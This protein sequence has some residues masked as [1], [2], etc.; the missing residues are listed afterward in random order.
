[1]YPN[2]EALLISY[3]PWTMI[4]PF[5]FERYPTVYFIVHYKSNAMRLF[6]TTHIGEG[7]KLVLIVVAFYLAI[8]VVTYLAW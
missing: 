4:Y 1:M 3:R 2:P 6:D 5:T 8:T 7:T